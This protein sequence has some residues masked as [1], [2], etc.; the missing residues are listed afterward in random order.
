MR[1][2]IQRALLIVLLAVTAVWVPRLCNAQEYRATITGTVADTAKAVIPK[3][4]V[5]VRNLDT[6][7][8]INT[9]TSAA[10]AYTVPYLRPAQRYE[11]TVEVPGFKKT[12]HPAVVLSISQVI[13]LDFTLQV[14]NAASEVQPTAAPLLTTRPSLNCRLTAATRWRC[15]MP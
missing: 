3:A 5:T 4:A 8:V 10:G 7:E 12:T 1:S 14:G 6:G 13:T 15:L 2:M 11:V 9:L